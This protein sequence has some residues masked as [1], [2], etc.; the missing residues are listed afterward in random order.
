MIRDILDM[1][2]P[3]T[4]CICG[5]RLGKDE[6][7]ICTSCFLFLPHTGFINDL[8]C[9]EM[10]KTFWW[11]VKNFEKAFALMVYQAHSDSAHPIY[12]L[13][14]NDKPDI[15]TDLGVLMG[16]MVKEV[17]FFDDIDAILPVPLAKKRI[18][19]RGYN[20]SYMIALGLHD[21]SGLP[22]YNNVL[23][24]TSFSGSQT[25]KDRWDRARNVENAFQLLDGS[26]VSGK[27]ILIVDDV[28]TT[29]ATI[30]SVAKELQKEKNVH[31]SVV[32]I[33]YA[34]QYKNT[35]STSK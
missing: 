23:R 7:V 30:C 32:S 1:I 15:G 13:K 34:G 14:Y 12:Q 19:E 26:K 16:R 28:V 33:G 10:A 21:V 6:N 20:Q 8:Y 5:R 3:R 17:G 11:R 2:T 4:C 25:Q 35:K 24:R 31:I 22:I 18:R 27:H 9:N 29:G